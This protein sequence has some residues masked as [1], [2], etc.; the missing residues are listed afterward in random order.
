[1]KIKNLL[2]TVIAICGIATT[3]S[4]Q[5]PNYVPTNGL[6]GWWPFNGNAND[7]SGN[8]NDG[9]I[10]NVTSDSN[11]FGQQNNALFF[12]GI[13][14]GVEL[15]GN[16][17]PLTNNSYTLN[18]W[19]KLTTNTDHL[20]GFTVFDDR[21][22]TVWDY[23][24]RYLI[25][26][27]TN[28]VESYYQM[29]DVGPRIYY[30]NVP[31]FTWIN[32]TCIYNSTAEIMYFFKNGVIVDSTVCSNNW[33]LTGNRKIQIGRAQSPIIYNGNDYFTGHW[34]G[35]I[36]DIG[37]WNRALTQQEV[38]DL[39][40]STLGLPVPINEN[41]INLYPNPTNSN[42]TL[43]V[44]SELVGKRYSIRD[45]SGRIILDGKISSTQEQ[46][47]LQNVARGAY[48]LSIENSTSVTKLIKQ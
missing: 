17:F 14:S 40:N 37:I 30:N 43:E 28:P 9:V 26:L 39:Y 19:F 38:T 46:I 47:D 24:G 35:Q 25:D 29:S 31:S 34:K 3:A 16:S 4:A 18:T 15:P 44:S 12:N 48:Y 1:M 36:D 27:A 33:F 21:D 5:V 42:I 8:G 32:I 10:Y 20:N 11:R 13:N 23:K 22:S 41:S 7:E 6:V 45:F 2:L